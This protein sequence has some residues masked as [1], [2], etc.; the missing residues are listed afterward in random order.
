MKFKETDY[1]HLMSNRQAAMNA[2]RDAAMK[3][4]GIA[5]A[6]FELESAAH[7]AGLGFIATTAQ[8]F[9]DEDEDDNIRPF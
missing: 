7:S 4:N 2:V 1:C 6:L 9:R 5:G 3:G 8:D